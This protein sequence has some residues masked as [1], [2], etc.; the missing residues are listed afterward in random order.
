MRRPLEVGVISALVLLG[1]CSAG[2][3]PLCQ[4]AQNLKDSVQGLTQVDLQS[5]GVDAVTSA[6]D[7]VDSA[8]SA[9]GTEASNTFGPQVDAIRTQLT[10]LGDA[11]QQVQGGDP[12]TSVA[13]AVAASLSALKTAL[14][15]L[16]STAQAQDCDLD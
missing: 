4:D 12:V 2:Q 3:S 13:P 1:S 9:L 14:S 15:D 5:G 6:L 11:V 10:A 16:Q 7:K 8:I